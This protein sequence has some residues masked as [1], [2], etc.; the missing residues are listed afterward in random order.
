MLSEISEAK[1]YKTYKYDITY[2]QDLK[3]TKKW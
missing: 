3:N 1:T 2:I